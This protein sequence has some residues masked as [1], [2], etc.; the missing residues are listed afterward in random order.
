MR[1]DVQHRRRRWGSRS[2]SDF[3]E[4]CSYL[5]EMNIYSF[6]FYFH[7]HKMARWVNM[8]AQC[9]VDRCKVPCYFFADILDLIWVNHLP[10]A[11]GAELHILKVE[12]TAKVLII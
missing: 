4:F 10:F 2:A 12:D 8:R 3:V 9:A 1:T 11:S 7:D 6:I 5:V